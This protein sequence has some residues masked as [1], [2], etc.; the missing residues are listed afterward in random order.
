MSKMKDDA[1]TPFSADDLPTVML[2]NESL[3]HF[4]NTIVEYVYRKLF[5]RIV[6]DRGQIFADIGLDRGAVY[7][8]EDIVK[9]THVL[10]IGRPRVDNAA[11]VSRYIINSY[12]KIVRLLE[13]LRK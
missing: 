11:D 7:R 3:E 1:L 6:K 5:I 10:P 9:K 13:D 8:A 4:G 12:P 2:D